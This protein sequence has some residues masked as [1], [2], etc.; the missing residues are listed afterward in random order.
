MKNRGSDGR[1]SCKVYGLANTAEV[2]I[3]VMTGS[4][5]E[6]DLNGKREG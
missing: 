1:G 2:T 5:D 6:G 3:V 4:G